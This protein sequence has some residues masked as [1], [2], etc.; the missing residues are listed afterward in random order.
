MPEFRPRR[1]T[2]I[3]ERNGQFFYRR[4]IPVASRAQF[5][6]L[7]EWNIRLEGR[8]QSERVSEAHAYAHRHNQ[9]IANGIGGRIF[10]RVE[11][12]QTLDGPD[13]SI[14]LDATQIP[15]PPGSRAFPQGSKG[16][17]HRPRGC[18]LYV[19]VV[20]LENAAEIRLVGNR[21]PQLLERGIPVPEGFQEGEREL[22][23]VERAFGKV[24]DGLFDFDCVHVSVPE[25]RLEQAGVPGRIGGSSEVPDDESRL[26]A[27]LFICGIIVL[28]PERATPELS[29]MLLGAFPLS[30]G[31]LQSSLKLPAVGHSW[32]RPAGVQ[33]VTD[34]CAWFVGHLG[35][36]QPPGA[37]T[38]IPDHGFR[39]LPRP[40]QAFTPSLFFPLNAS[41]ERPEV[42]YHVSQISF[43]PSSFVQTR[44][45]L[46]PRISQVP[47]I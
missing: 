31:M 16:I 11:E 18:D 47:T 20:G 19:D 44:Q 41:T 24:G 7:T 8:T 40:Y 45:N 38:R 12:S 29:Q 17:G 2:Y 23:R 4:A 33:C 3:K 34:L 30:D 43:P 5:G 13:V 32:P 39:L 10:P 46:P 27:R 25:D 26:D 6:G 42:R 1:A 36:T 22:H 37:H 35:P 28:L 21:R 15:L 9:E 14:R